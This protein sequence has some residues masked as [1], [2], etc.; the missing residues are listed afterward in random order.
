MGRIWTVRGVDGQVV[1][2]PVMQLSLSFDHRV[3]D[4]ALGSRVLQ[5]VAEFLRDPALAFMLDT[6]WQ[7]EQPPP[8]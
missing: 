7:R 1:A 3:I 2:R 8:T 5:S 6:G 4:G